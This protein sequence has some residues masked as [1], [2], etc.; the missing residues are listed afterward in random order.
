MQMLSL[1][2]S[3]GLFALNVVA[4]SILLGAAALVMGFFARRWALPVRHGLLCVV[5]A[6]TL[7]SPLPIWIAS[8]QGFGI[9]P[10]SLGSADLEA[11]GDAGSSASRAQGVGV[12][13]PAE[14]LEYDQSNDG[15]AS[16]E[17]AGPSTDERSARTREVASGS[18][19]AG[20]ASAQ[21]RPSLLQLWKRPSLR[22]LSQLGILF[23]LVWAAVASWFLLRVV[24]G[25]FAIRQLRRSLRPASNSRLIEAARQI[26]PAT[27]R[28]PCA[29]V[30]VSSFAPAPLT[31][32]W[33]RP[34]IVMPEGLA[35]SLDDE[36]LV[37]VLAHEAAHVARHDTA[38]ALLQQS[39]AV[40]FWWNPLVAAV[41]R[42]INQLR[43]RICDDHVVKQFGD[44]L[45][46]AEAII[47]IAEWSVAPRTRLPSTV[48]LLDDGDEVEHRI[49]RL[50][51]PERKVSVSLNR[52]SAT[53]IVL[54]GIVFAAVPLIPV[55]RAQTTE[56]TT[57]NDASRKAVSQVRSQTDDAKPK[58]TPILKPIAKLVSG[59]PAKPADIREFSAICDDWEL[60]ILGYVSQGQ[61]PLL[62]EPR[63]PL[64]GKEKRIAEQRLAK[65]CLALAEKYPGTTGELA[66][67]Y[68]AAMR[69]Y[70]L[71]LG[72]KALELLVSRSE[73]AD[74]A[75]LNQAILLGRRPRIPGNRPHVVQAIAPIIISR[76]RTIPDDPS[77]AALLTYICR[78]L[79]RSAEGKELQPR[80]TEAADLIAE[81]YAAS[82]EI[83][84]F[85][86]VL[87]GRHDSPRW[88][89]R[90]EPHLRKILSANEDRW[91]RCT[92]SLALASIAQLDVG[93]QA[94]A[95]QLYEKFIKEFD[96][97]HEYHAQGIEEQLRARA[98]E[99]LLGMRFA[100]IGRA[101]PEMVGVDL[102][103]EPMRLSDY[104]GKVVLVSFWA[105]WCSPCMKFIPHERELAERLKD[106]PFAIVGVNADDDEEP[107]AHAVKKYKISW[108][109][110]RDA[111]PGKES[112]SDEWHALYP[113]LYL[114]DHEGIIRKRWTGAPAPAELNRM[115]DELVAAALAK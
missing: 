47:K 66:A 115:V 81:H 50:A 72:K 101:A 52:W 91:V 20:S 103:G 109:S 49:T 29:P 96:G 70:E 112:I 58:P 107:A 113:T 79:A 11:P 110:F 108:P 18:A 41:N 14:I 83:F 39:A 40:G 67:L 54:L 30:C 6:S 95:E 26:L 84:N 28:E 48:A 10:V 86:E 57:R 93:R 12:A 56:P 100:S 21:S 19:S 51:E 3:A 16:S 90:F 13:S 89:P 5:L 37:S 35:E 63:A 87:G 77:G 97:Q 44:G 65:R 45:P 25:L 99:R 4:A 17:S 8:S 2:N 24:H 73:T 102:E 7:A 64:M 88:A 32:G 82:P 69:G 75:Q 104:R 68:L 9:V 76:L 111:R 74:L 42:R 55:V 31:L 106:Q 46:L 22:A 62:P 15:F 1:S 61:L 36:Q 92:A 53:L 71:E 78:R 23:A 80:F 34:V 98:G 33:W 38:I 43:E 105:T 27:G 59:Q 60:V 85:G 114:I 94:E